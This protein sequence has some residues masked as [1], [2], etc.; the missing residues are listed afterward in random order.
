[1][2]NNIEEWMY[3]YDH[4]PRYM[5]SNFGRARGVDGELIKPWKNKEG[6]YHIDIHYTEGDYR[7]KKHVKLNRIIIYYFY[8]DQEK[9][10]EFFFDK[11]YDVDH[12]DRN[13]GN[14]HISNLRF[15]TKG[16]NLHNKDIKG[17]WFRK[18]RNKFQA[19]ITVQGKHISLGSFNNP[20][21]AQLAYQ[22][23]SIKYYGPVSKWFLTGPEKIKPKY[24]KITQ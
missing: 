17:F 21:F 16:E 2:S 8:P 4:D 10:P 9:M 15:L 12:I 3:T 23:A 18:D 13:P 20:D 14:N 11:K 22:E 7:K 5:V 19:A 6:R 1:M 24:R